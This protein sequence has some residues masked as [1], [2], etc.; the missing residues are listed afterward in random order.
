MCLARLK[1]KRV[2]RS[3]FGY[4]V[5]IANL[6]ATGNDEIK[7]RFRCMGVIGAKRFAFRY[8]Y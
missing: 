1:Q 6:A 4:S 7:L 8:S 2:A 5:L 3:D